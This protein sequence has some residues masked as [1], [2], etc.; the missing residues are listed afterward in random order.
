MK[1][2]QVNV[3]TSTVVR[4][5]EESDNTNKTHSRANWGVMSGRPIGSMESTSISHSSIP[6]WPATFTSGRVQMWTLHLILHDERHL[7]NAW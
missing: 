7:A 3:A 4:H 2:D 5:L 1:A 6:Y